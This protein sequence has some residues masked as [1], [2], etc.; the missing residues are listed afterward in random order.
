MFSAWL[1]S[2][3]NQFLTV[4]KQDLESGAQKQ[5]LDSILSQAMYFGQSFGRVGA[6]FRLSLVPIL[7]KAV[8]DVALDHLEGRVVKNFVKSISRK[9]QKYIYFLGSEQRFK[10]GIDQL[11]LKA[12]P[13]SSNIS[14]SEYLM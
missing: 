9:F 2:K 13:S 5:S 6:D 3:L 1:N 14:T 4:L 11:A 10:Q 7:S 8:L 12:M